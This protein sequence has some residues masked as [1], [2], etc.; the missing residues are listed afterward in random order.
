VWAEQSTCP[1]RRVGAVLTRTGAGGKP[2]IVA[3]AFNGSPPGEP[4]CT[5]VGCF[6]VDGHCKRTVHAEAN[7]VAQ[8]AAHGHPTAGAVLFTLVK[9]CYECQKLL[10]AAGI[11]EWRWLEDYEDHSGAP[12]LTGGKRGQA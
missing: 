12:D 9:P 2:Y 6:I 3:T 11:D 10:R 7:A 8:A 5:D 1:R 4:H